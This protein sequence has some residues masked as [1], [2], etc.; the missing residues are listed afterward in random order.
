MNITININ[1]DKNKKSLNINFY[2]I[3]I[4]IFGIF[5]RLY[6]IGFQQAW[7]DEI[8][9]LQVSDPDI[10]LKE[11]HWLIMAREGFPHFYFLTLKFLS[12]IFGHSIV[13]LRLFSALFGILSIYYIYLIGK[14][15]ISRNA[16]Y[17]AATVLT[18]SIFHIYHSQEARCYSLWVF[19]VIISIYRLIILNKSFT[20]KN[21][22][23]LGI[24][25]GLIPNAHPLG[26]LNVGVIYA[27][28]FFIFMY[29]K[30]K[31]NIFKKSMLSFI[32][33]ALLFIPVI[34]LFTKVSNITSFWIPAP[35]F[36][37]IK[38][39]FFELSGSNTFIFYLYVGSLLFMLIHLF[40][41]TFIKNEKDNYTMFLLILTLIWIIINAGVIIYKSYTDISIIWNRY[42][43]GLLPLFILSI[44]YLICLIKNKYLIYLNVIIFSFYTLYIIVIE[45]KYYNSISKTEYKDLADYISKE[46][47]NN[48][49]I[50]STFGF[51]TNI[52][53]K[54]TP[55]YK[56]MREITFEDYLN[57][58]KTGVI[59]KEAFWFFDGNLRPYNLDYENQLFLEQ[60]Y[61]LDNEFEKFDCWTKH[62]VPKEV[63][64]NI[65]PINTI[66]LNDFSPLNKYEDGNVYLFQN[67]SIKTKIICL[68]IGKYSLDIKANSLP[69]K[70]INGENAKIQFK[71]N[72][73]IIGI[74]ELSGERIKEDN[75]FIFFS[76]D[77]SSK[78]LSIEFINDFSS[79]DEDRNVIIYNVKLKK[80]LDKI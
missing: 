54:N 17:V 2:L 65:K 1:L 61:T 59:K 16:G 15:I 38:V 34:P 68:E 46:N 3:S 9:T 67:G 60:N 25:T 50:Y 47:K 30:E 64:E 20:Y 29:S 72:D 70:P 12:T 23:L 57:E 33:T 13:V 43:I 78:I 71:V 14:E 51:V 74:K 80:L 40:Y 21:A 19:F 31:L 39:A 62:Y 28:L 69:E 58:V 22:I 73:K 42:F 32:I 53:F 6:N 44:T 79:G 49:R 52:L 11:T 8:S 5:L 48:D 37:T 55:S 36:E 24:A 45:R 35:S 76:N 7:L 56:L 66:A 77:E 4:L 41:K 26:V 75:S 10:T 27:T 63:V 18:V